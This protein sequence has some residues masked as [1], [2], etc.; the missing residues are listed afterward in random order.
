MDFP[1][2]LYRLSDKDRQLTQLQF[3]NYNSGVVGV[4][5]TGINVHF[6]PVP[7]DKLWVV[8]SYFADCFAG[9]A[10]K[11]IEVWG[12]LY[13][14]GS[15]GQYVKMFDYRNQVSNPNHLVFTSG[16]W[17]DKGYILCPGWD[18]FIQVQFDAGAANNSVEVQVVYFEIPRG[19]FVT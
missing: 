13:I 4:A 11:V 12:G 14:P 9:A 7:L 6:G 17:G 1:E 19:G 2:Y 18:P 15:N 16:L 5:S 8:Q 3:S 10:Q